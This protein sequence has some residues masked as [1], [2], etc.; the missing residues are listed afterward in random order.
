M[1]TAIITNKYIKLQGHAGFHENGHDLVCC[2]I[3]TLTC[4]LINSLEQLTDS[5]I[6][7][8]EQSG[9]VEIRLK[10]LDEKGSFLIDS[11]YMGLIAI[12]QQYECISFVSANE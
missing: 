6:E 4:N 9:Y 12:N 8:T 2:A 7:H 3:S 11:W 10:S 1:I 5:E